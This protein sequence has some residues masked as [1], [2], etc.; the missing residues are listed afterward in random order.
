MVL[1]QLLT[2]IWTAIKAPVVLHQV[3]LLRPIAIAVL[4]N[5]PE[6]MDWEEFMIRSQTSNYAFCLMSVMGLI[7]RDSAEDEALAWEL[8]TRLR[9]LHQESRRRAPP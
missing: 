1:R 9:Q 6:E 3:H 8:G 2:Q 4:E 5:E 7:T